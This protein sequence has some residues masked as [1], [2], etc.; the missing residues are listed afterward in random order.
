VWSVTYEMGRSARRI[1]R[2]YLEDGAEPYSLGTA[3]A[4]AD[5]IA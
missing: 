4:V 2:V 3:R 5:Q 1:K